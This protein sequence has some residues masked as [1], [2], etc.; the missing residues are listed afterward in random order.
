MAA[1][2]MT[3]AYDGGRYRGWQRQG[4]TENTIQ[5]KVEQVLSRL[6]HEKV[7]IAASGRTDEGVHALG[8]VVSFH[9]DLVFDCEELTRDCNRYLPKDIRVLSTVLTYPRFHARLSAVGK[10]YE[11][12]IDNGPVARVFERRYLTRIEEPLQVDAMREAA[13]FFL[14]EH[15]FASFCDSRPKKKST[16][17]RLCDLE[18]EEKEGI[19]TLTFHG[20]GFLYHMVRILS[21][22]L[23]EVG[24]GKRSPYGMLRILEAKDRRQAGMLAPPQG[25]FLR[26]V[27]YPL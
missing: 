16:V 2:R 19:V 14:G 8:Q 7:E 25:L 27:D 3:L 11:Y 18:V 9:T 21:G 10:W 23:I 12:R 6:L 26:A 13:A 15:D 4:N 22:T 20:D 1:Y 5:E 17:R 24:Q